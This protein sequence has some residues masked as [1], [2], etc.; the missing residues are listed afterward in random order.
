MCE[1]SLCYYKIII[2]IGRTLYYSYIIIGRTTFL[3]S[4]K[5]YRRKYPKAKCSKINN[6]HHSSFWKPVPDMG[7]FQACHELLGFQESL[8]VPSVKQKH[9]LLPLE[10]VCLQVFPGLHF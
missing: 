8:A 1:L 3:L 4:V 7:S 9:V 6:T 5:L 2:I 10:I